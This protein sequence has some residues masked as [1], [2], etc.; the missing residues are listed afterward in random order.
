MARTSTKRDDIVAA[1]TRL[2]RE[3]GV[4]AAS[5]STIVAESGTSAGTIYHHFTN[6]NDVVIAVAKHAIAEPITAILTRPRTEPLSPG[7]LFREVADAVLS[8]RIDSALIVQ[9]WAGSSTDP[10]LSRMLLSLMLA[11]RDVP[12]QFIE[13]WLRSHGIPDAEASAR[14]LPLAQVAVGQAMGLLAQRTLDPTLQR[15]AYIDE[16]VRLLDT[17][18]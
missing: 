2:I 17:L 6:K 14:A 10:E 9:L 15:E 12:V 3:K 5:I 16:A 18:R 4:H 11:V 8:G 1:A 7:G 13:A